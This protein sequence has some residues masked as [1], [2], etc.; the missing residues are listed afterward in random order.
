MEV[1]GYRIWSLRYIKDYGK[2]LLA[3]PFKDLIWYCKRVRAYCS[4]G[5]VALH[6]SRGE[7]E[8]GIYSAAGLPELFMWVGGWDMLLEA[9]EVVGIVDNYGYIAVHELRGKKLG[10]RSE[11]CQINSLL[12]IPKACYSCFFLESVYTRAVYVYFTHNDIAVICEKCYQKMKSGDP[13]MEFMPI[14]DFYQ[15]VCDYYDIPLIEWNLVKSTF[16]KSLREAIKI[17][18][19]LKIWTYSSLEEYEQLIKIYEKM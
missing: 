13:T 17:K 18:M 16:L 14:T 10:Y 6:L 3:S 7:C 4:F 8:C 15:S 2:W 1:R 12:E 11:E 5:D 9:K 19:R